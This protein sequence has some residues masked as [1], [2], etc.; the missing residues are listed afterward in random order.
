[1]RSSEKEGWTMRATWRYLS[2]LAMTA[3]AALTLAGCSDRPTGGP[4]VGTSAGT[5]SPVSSSAGA[6]GLRVTVLLDSGRIDP[7]FTID[8]GDAI[9]E[10][11]QLYGQAKPA[12]ES[13]PGQTA[14]PSGSGYKG[15]QIENPGGEGGLP[16]Q[17][18]VYQ[19]RVQ[20]RDAGGAERLFADGGA[21]E[22]FLLDQAVRAKALDQKAAEQ[23]RAA[24]AR[25]QRPAR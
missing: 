16:R 4:S 2:A 3:V 19:D 11:A 21:C 9:G 23:I 7:T 20:A 6:A 13:A 17:I 15:M 8:D 14:A 10:L 12:P 24:R 22:R 5:G 18:T 1:M 25:P